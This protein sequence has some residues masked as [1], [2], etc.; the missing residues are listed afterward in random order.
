MPEG[1]AGKAE[2]DG[3]RNPTRK[4]FHA[5]RERDHEMIVKDKNKIVEF[6]EYKEPDREATLEKSTYRVNS[7]HGRTK[8]TMC[9]YRLEDGNDWKG[10]CF[11]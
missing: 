4:Q 6:Q 8:W 3:W 9:W 11:S 1:L 5:Y 7:Y 10:Y 2:D